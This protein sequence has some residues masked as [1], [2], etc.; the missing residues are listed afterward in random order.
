MIYQEAEK[1]LAADFPAAFIYQ[2]SNRYL[3]KPYVR[4]YGNNPDGRILT[5]DLYLVAH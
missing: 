3:I 1:I 4:G 5:K 2:Y